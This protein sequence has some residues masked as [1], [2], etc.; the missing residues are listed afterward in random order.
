[1]DSARRGARMRG[2]SRREEGMMRKGAR[3][4]GRERA[5]G[6]CR[7]TRPAWDQSLR[8]ALHGVAQV[9]QDLEVELLA[10]VAEVER[11]L[12]GVVAHGLG[13]LEGFAVHVLE[14]G[15]DAFAGAGHAGSLDGSGRQARR[16][17]AGIGRGLVA[18][19]ELRRGV[20]QVP[21]GIEGCR[22]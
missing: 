7:G 21:L 6:E 22:H 3:V 4:V 9:E 12:L 5:R 10:P 13:A 20:E 15:E 2:T 11:L 18:H 8:T 17:V 1:M 16:L 14:V 19:E